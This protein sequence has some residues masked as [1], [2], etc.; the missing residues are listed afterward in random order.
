MSDAPARAARLSFEARDE[1][2][3][4]VLGGETIAESA[5]TP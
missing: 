1:T 2:V 4:V 5:N 3:R